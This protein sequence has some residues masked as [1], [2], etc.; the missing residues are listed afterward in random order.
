MVV[1]KQPTP[2]L[3][4]TSTV[5]IQKRQLILIRDICS[6]LCDPTYAIGKKLTPRMTQALANITLL[7]DPNVNIN[8]VDLYRFKEDVEELIRTGKQNAD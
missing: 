6:A 2:V 8:E 4:D 3:C 5:L 7:T 1:A